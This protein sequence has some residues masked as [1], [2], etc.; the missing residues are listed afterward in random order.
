MAT[1]SLSVID[2]IRKAAQRLEASA[3]YQWGH[4][5]SCNCGFLA[6]QVTQL[7]KEE[8]HRRAMMRYGDWSEQLNDYCPTSALP[9]DD[10]I[11]ELIAFGFDADDLRH[12]ERLSDGRVLR[13]LPLPERNLHHNVKRDAVKYMRAW[14]DLLEAELLQ[15][16]TL[17]DATPAEVALN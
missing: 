4:M 16:I 2:A 5:G 17:P 8:I 9:I 14:A 6:Q 13:N 10:T 7:S 15:A 11:S 12:L 3:A 1:P